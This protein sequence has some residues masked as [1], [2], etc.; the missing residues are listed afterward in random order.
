MAGQPGPH[1]PASIQRRAASQLI[2]ALIIGGIFL[3]FA[4]W[5]DRQVDLFRSLRDTYQPH[6]ATVVVQQQA[7]TILGLILLN[8]FPILWAVRGQ[9]VGKMV[10]GIRVVTTAGGHV[11]IFRAY[12]RL[13]GL[14]FDTFVLT[15]GYW[16]AAF[17]AE[18]RTLHDFVAG[19]VVV[20]ASG[21]PDSEL[22][23]Q[24]APSRSGPP[25]EHQ[26][27]RGGGGTSPGVTETRD[28]ATI[29]CPT[30]GRPMPAL[31]AFCGGCGGR[32][33]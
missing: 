27:A 2:D 25:V 1:A 4:I 24:P 11:S 33:R 6:E 16:I 20:S 23:V 8:Y 15:L 18:R 30:C 12:L 13:L 28:P 7:V 32:L 3:F 9:T 22:P 26:A 5:I 19:T 10:T 21:S 31:A 29:A 17:N 14:L